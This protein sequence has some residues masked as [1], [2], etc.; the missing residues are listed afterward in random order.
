M[1]DRARVGKTKPYGVT[2]AMRA[3]VIIVAAVWIAVFLAPSAAKADPT[4]AG[5]SAAIERFTIQKRIAPVFGGKGFGRVGQYEMLIGTAYGSLDP[6]A[7]H[8][9]VIAD[10]DKAPLNAAGR[11]EYSTQ[12]AILRPVDISRSSGN[13]IYQVINRSFGAINADKLDDAGLTQTMLERGD[14]VV[15]AAW[16]GELSAA[17]ATQDAFALRAFFGADPLYATLP[18]ALEGGKPMVR[19]IRQEVEAFQAI[20][21]APAIRADLTY[22]AAAPSEME[23]FYRRFESD[24]PKAAPNGTVRLTDRTSIAITPVQGAAVYDILYNATDPVVSGI[25]LTVPRDLISFLRRDGGDDARRGSPLAGKDGKSVVRRAYAFGLSQSGR[26]LRDFLK[27][28]FNE[29]AHGLRVFDGIIPV[30]AGGRGGDFNRAFAQPGVIPGELSGHRKPELFPFAYPVLDDPVTGRRDGLLKQCRKTTTC[31]KLMQIDSATEAT[32]YY[33]WMLTTQPNGLPIDR[34]PDNVRLYAVAGSDHPAGLIRMGICRAP[35]PAP[36]PVR[37]FLRAAF[38]AMDD[39]VRLGKAPPP[40][41]YPTLSDGTLTTVETARANYPSI[42][43]YPFILA[44]SVPENWVERSPLPTSTGRYPLL[45]PTMDGDGNMIGGV[46]HPLQ[47]VPTGTL[48]GIGARMDGYAPENPCPS[49]GE[50][51]AFAQTKAERQTTGDTRPSLEERYRGGITEIALRRQAVART[52]VAE[53]YLLAQDG[54]VWTEGGAA[55]PRGDHGK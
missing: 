48:S 54:G 12:V 8:N 1:S 19:R 22:P 20:S 55:Q 7:R 4:S 23:V 29:D 34:Q 18:P 24:A 21:R 45:V 10:L 33:G 49:V 11:V 25:G 50:S 15:E 27:L 9:R 17:R 51:I 30:I 52:L 31:P 28:G 41:R 2:G 39:W 38:V 14:I 32:L 43:G 6:H 35:A 26:Y 46:Q 16:Q 37:P 3:G 5:S 44:R 36:V 53:R 42:P 40:S 47:A 13:L